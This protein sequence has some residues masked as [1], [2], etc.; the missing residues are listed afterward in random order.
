MPTRLVR[1]FCVDPG[2]GSGRRQR[3]RLDDLDRVCLQSLLR[4][5]KRRDHGGVLIDLYNPRRAARS[6]LETH[7]TAAGEEIEHGDAFE[8]PPN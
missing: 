8:L 6:G 4:V 3:I 5:A 7:R 2:V 1:L